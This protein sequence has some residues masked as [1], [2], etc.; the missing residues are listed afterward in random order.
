MEINY[1]IYGAF[2]ALW[3]IL[4]LYKNKFTVLLIPAF[5]PLYLLRFEVLGIPVYFIEGLIL[6]SA[7]PV[8]YKILKGEED[9][10]QKNFKCKIFYLFKRIFFVDFLKRKQRPFLDF[11]KS[12]FLPITLFVIACLISASIVP[13]DSYMHAL[14]I[15]KSWVLIP[16]IF[17]II[18]YHTLNNLE[19]INYAIY[20]YIASAVFLGIW[21]LYQ[22]LSGHFITIDNRASGPFESANY[23]AMYISPAFVY[24]SVRFI[25]TFI[26]F[27]VES[28]FSKWGAIESRAYLSWIVALLFAV[29]ILTQSYGGIIGVFLALFL[30]IIYERIQWQKYLK[31]TRIFLNK[32]IGFILLILFLGGTLT[33]FMNIEKFQ[34]LVK[35]DERTSISTRFEIW[36]VGAQLIK[37]NPIL[38]IGLGQYEENYVQRAEEI[39]GKKPFEEKRLHSHNVFMS[40]WLNSGL[41]GLIAFL[42]IVIFAYLQIK[43]VDLKEK[44]NILLACISM[45]TYILMHGLIDVTYWKN[46]LA[47]IFWLIMACIFAIEKNNYS[48]I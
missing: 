32:L 33:A 8:F 25:Q 17:F 21:A 18:L 31:K 41:L 7:I 34:N 29:L 37:E 30:Y 13:S 1:F 26:H 47:L 9:I 46:D 24:V 16:L 20:A 6:I 22:G 12:P 38:G 14:G 39:L 3:L 15:L 44:K 42:W 36:T 10:L 27:K 35:F 4:A 2:Y 5:F 19:D 43:R 28:G 40:F 48:K 45:L 23:L 11:L